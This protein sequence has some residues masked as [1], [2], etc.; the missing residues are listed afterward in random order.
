MAGVDDDF[1]YRDGQN[2]LW[3]PRPEGSGPADGRDPVWMDRG[4]AGGPSPDGGE[5]GPV[6]SALAWIAVIVVLVG[7]A[8]LVWQVGGWLFGAAQGGGTVGRCQQYAN[9]QAPAA[10]F[11]EQFHDAVWDSCIDQGLR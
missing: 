5:L 9:E 3:L 7:A 11:G 2:P 6:G 10:E 4:D 8:A 1:I